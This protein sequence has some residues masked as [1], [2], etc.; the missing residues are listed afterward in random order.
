MLS[1]CAL[2]G[3][4]SRPPAS[5]I[6]LLS[7]AM[8]SAPIPLVRLCSDH[9]RYAANRLSRGAK[10]ERMQHGRGDLHRT[11]SPRDLTDPPPDKSTPAS[12]TPY[13]TT[14]AFIP[15][16]MRVARA[17]ARY[18]YSYLSAPRAHH[19]PPPTAPD[20][21]GEVSKRRISMCEHARGRTDP[22]HGVP[23]SHPFP[24]RAPHDEAAK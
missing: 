24:P 11:H 18:P 12:H 10:G 2:H 17:P 8:P 6:S 23:Y 22:P 9:H 15:D 7:S 5:A 1:D 14:R 4:R 16:H 3:R 19:P 20:E 13:Y 21:A